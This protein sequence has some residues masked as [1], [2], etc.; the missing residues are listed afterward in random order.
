MGR[1]LLRPQAR[2]DL[3]TIWDYLAAVQSPATA[4]AVLRTIFRRL[5]AL[6]DYPL[7][8]RT[9]DDIRPGVRGSPVGR[10]VI[11]YY[12]RDEGIIVSRV[13]YGGRDLPDAYDEADDPDP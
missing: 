1:L 2:D 11:F 8:G 13:L 7:L 5:S 12:P 4:D 3:D 6:A 10:Y 9:R